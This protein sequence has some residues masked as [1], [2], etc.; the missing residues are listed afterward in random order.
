MVS[1]NFPDAPVMDQVATMGSR[2]WKWN[3]TVWKSVTTAV[4]LGPTGPTGPQGNSGLAGEPGLPGEPGLDS[5]VPGPTGPEGPP[6]PEGPASTVTGPTGPEGLMGPT[7]NSGAQGIEGEAGSPGPAGPEGP[8]GS[9]GPQGTAGLTGADGPPGPEGPLGPT[10]PLGPVGLQGIPGNDG[11][12][13]AVGPM[14][15]TGELGPVG[16]MGQDSIVPGPT[17]PQG[18]YTVSSTEPAFP[19][20]GDIWFNSIVGSTFI[21]YDNYWVGVG[22]G[23][24]YS[25][26]RTV[27]SNTIA[28]ANEGLIANTLDGSF[29]ITLPENPIV[30]ESV[31]I[32]DGKNS[33][34]RNGVIISGGIEL[35]EERTDDMLL[36]VDR[37]SII[38]RFI[39]SAYGWKVV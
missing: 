32:I 16:P 8:I 17:G 6:G 19:V 22:G 1:M 3:G 18:T 33:F 13:G 28:V 34:K 20:S 31:A 36:N 30:G 4:S 7:G 9:T 15:P 23:V 24:A 14:G 39:N 37:A 11:T 12:D 2:S 10:G 27:N 26:W 29:S 35:I 38:F 21:Y 25:T 5:T